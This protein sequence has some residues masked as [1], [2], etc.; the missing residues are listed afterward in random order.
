V[1]KPYVKVRARRYRLRLLNGSVSRLLKIAFVTES[2]QRV[3]HHM[4]ANDGNIMEH[5]VAFPNAQSADLPSQSIGERFDIVVDFS[6]YAVGRKLYLVNLLEHDDGRGPKQAIPLAD[7]MSGR[8]VGDPAVGK[9]LEFRIEK[10]D[11]RDQSMNPAD[12]VEGKKKMIPRPAIG[13]TELA[14][15]RVRTFEFGRSGGTDGKPWTIKTDGGQGLVADLKRVSAAPTTGTLEIWRVSTP[16]GWAHPVH[17]H[18]EEGRI[19]NRDG[20][21]PK[22]WEKWA[23]KDMYTIG[24]TA[25]LPRSFDLAIRFREFMGTFVEHCHNTQHEDHAMLLRWDARNPG[26]TIAIPAPFPTWEG[27]TYAPSH[28]LISESGSSVAAGGN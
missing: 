6:R 7:V 24:D 2:G 28:D 9:F 26:Q 4:I 8:Y 19:L 3:P 1:Y 23:R 14:T 10:Y 12:Y 13:A 21:P 27:V 17:V 22:L 16:G 15:A 18:F 5:A 25:G 20:G 11:G